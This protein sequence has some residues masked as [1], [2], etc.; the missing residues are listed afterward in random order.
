MSQKVVAILL[1]TLILSTGVV[2]AASPTINGMW[3]RLN[4]FINGADSVTVA[5][6]NIIMYDFGSFSGP[7]N[8]VIVKDGI[9]FGPWKIVLSWS[10]GL[11]AAQ[12][13]GISGDRIT[14]NQ[15]QLSSLPS[16]SVTPSVTYEIYYNGQLKASGT[17]YEYDYWSSDFSVTGNDISVSIQ[18]LGSS[19]VYGQPFLSVVV[20]IQ[21]WWYASA[22]QSSSGYTLSNFPSSKELTPYTIDFHPPEPTWYVNGQPTTDPDGTY[23]GPTIKVEL[24]HTPPWV[25]SSGLAVYNKP[26]VYKYYK[27]EPDIEQKDGVIYQ[28]QILPKGYI[29]IDAIVGYTLAAVGIA[30]VA[31]GMFRRHLY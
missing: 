2:S 15:F 5:S 29:T 24:K 19:V 22:T 7:D 8:G 13:L 31:I 1:V 11:Y 18:T 14:L 21:S 30:L 3:Y 25:I 4:N 26:E 20:F 17:L 28:S 10:P 27:V 16:T 9:I 6:V 12:K 23:S